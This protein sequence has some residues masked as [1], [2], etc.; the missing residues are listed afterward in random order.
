MIARELKMLGRGI[1]AYRV[2]K[3]NAEAAGEPFDQPQPPQLRGETVHTEEAIS[4]EGLCLAEPQLNNRGMKLNEAKKLKK[5]NQAKE[6][7]KQAAEEAEESA[8]K[9]GSA[10]YAMKSLFSKP[11][12]AQTL[13]AKGVALRDDP[14]RARQAHASRVAEVQREAARKS[15]GATRIRHATFGSI[16][17]LESQ[18]TERSARHSP[19][20]RLHGVRPREEDDSGNSAGSDADGES[21]SSG[22]S[23]PSRSSTYIRPLTPAGDVNDPYTAHKR[24]P[25][26]KN[27]DVI[28]SSS[29]EEMPRRQEQPGE[30]AQV[31]FNPWVAADVIGSPR[32]TGLI[33]ALT[34][35]LLEDFPDLDLSLSNSK[36]TEDK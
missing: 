13:E 20:S 18:D 7:A 11:S 5:E 35:D 17:I 9:M 33:G 29:V 15:A 2:A 14:R 25:Q 1:E 24:L 12:S 19:K 26:S 10:A 36:E 3:T 27:L 31:T 4:I 8:R 23:S 28:N 32:L 30:T 34:I 6:L 21:D 16:S 22:H